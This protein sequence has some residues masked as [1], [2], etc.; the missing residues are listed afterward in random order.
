[1]IVRI[2]QF[3]VAQAESNAAWGAHGPRGG[4][5]FIWPADANAFEILILEND[6][7]SRSLDK[8]FRQSQLRQLIGEVTAALLEEDQQIVARLDGPL[9]AGELLGVFSHLTTPE[10]RGRFAF[11]DARKFQQEPGVTAGSVRLCL[12][13]E[14]LASLCG[15]H[16]IGLE[17][18]VRLRI[19]SVAD[20]LV[21]PLLD[22]NST[23]DERW[24]EVLDHAGFMLSTVRGLQSM[25]ITTRRFSPAEARNR[26]LQRLT[27]RAQPA[28]SA[29]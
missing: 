19:F 17:H 18:E 16:D 12:S 1:M 13:A 3:D 27:S 10:G 25:H 24:S 6:E 22:I 5:E 2:N 20:E 23:E 29:I 7:Q 15:D 28:Q 14:R 9:Q 8:S 4:L 26:I 11:S 21:D